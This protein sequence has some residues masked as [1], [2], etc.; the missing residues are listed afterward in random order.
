MELTKH[1]EVAIPQSM[2]RTFTISMTDEEA[3]AIASALQT[4]E[5]SRWCSLTPNLVNLM[6]ILKN[7]NDP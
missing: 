1:D 5:M 2:R 4:I 6:T 7:R 3:R